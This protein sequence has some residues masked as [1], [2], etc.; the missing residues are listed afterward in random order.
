MTDKKE[1]RRTMKRLNLSLPGSERSERS[2][3]LFAE[4]AAT[5][6][7]AAARTVA[8]FASLPDEPDTAAALAAWAADKHLVVPR[9]AGDEMEFYDYLPDAMRSGAFGI[10]EPQGATPCPPERID[11]IVVP[12]TAFTRAGAR[13]GRGRGY[14][15]RYL[16]RPGFRARTVGVCYTH[17]LLD[18]LPVEPHDVP[19]DRVIAG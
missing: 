9:V 2:E 8:L 19:L 7:F 11:L 17:Q 13:I 1:I 5:A 16:S 6:E 14:Y 18:T 4:V 12:G 10:D 15:D 3:R